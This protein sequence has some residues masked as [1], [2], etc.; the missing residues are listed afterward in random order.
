[1]S[2]V[3]LAIDI[4]LPDEAVAISDLPDIG[5]QPDGDAAAVRPNC[6]RQHGV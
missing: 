4:A 3:Q 1:M 5:E 2:G 6:A